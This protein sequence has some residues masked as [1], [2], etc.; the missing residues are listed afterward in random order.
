[1]QL[2]SVT[3]DALLDKEVENLGTLVALELDDLSCL[4]VVYECAV[5]SEFLRNE[6]F[7]IR[8]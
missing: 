8:I 5:A 3:G 6:G 1:M 4:F 7:N 2:D